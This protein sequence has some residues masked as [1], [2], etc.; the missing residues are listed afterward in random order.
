MAMG[1]MIDSTAPT[2]VNPKQADKWPSW[3]IQVT[4][5]NDAPS[6][7]TLSSRALTGMTIDPV[8]RKSSAK[9]ASTTSA[10]A[11][12]APAAIDSARSMSE[13]A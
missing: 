4:T 8:M 5:P 3:K 1:G 7:T 11:Y 12:G 10:A 6:D 9:V 13:A 2:E